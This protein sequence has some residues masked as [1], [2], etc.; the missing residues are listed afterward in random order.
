MS[1]QLTSGHEISAEGLDTG[2]TLPPTLPPISAPRSKL[3]ATSTVTSRIVFARVVVAL[4]TPIG[5]LYCFASPM[6]VVPSAI[7]DVIE[8]KSD[9]VP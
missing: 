8:E 2:A 6:S 9:E 7:L 4:W 5:R 1:G 3:D